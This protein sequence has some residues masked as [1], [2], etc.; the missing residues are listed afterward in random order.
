MGELLSSAA[1]EL[2]RQT[3]VSKDVAVKKLVCVIA[4]AMVGIASTFA[5]E[6]NAG[7]GSTR[8]DDSAMFAGPTQDVTYQVIWLI[9]SD[10]ANREAYSGPASG[11]L[12]EAGYGRL[13]RAGSATAAVTIGQPSTVTGKSRYGQMSVLTSLLNTTEQDKLQ[14]KVQLRI[15]NQTPL[16]IES[17]MRVPMDRWF[18]IGSADSR[19]GLPKHD[20][21][22]KRGLAIMKITDGVLLLDSEK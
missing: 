7:P 13:V 15:Q 20:A 16:S 18:L 21:D 10:D 22:G 4:C 8:F 1:V 14:I 6:P 9:E 5:Q 19:V 3:T 12:T 2:E 17:T 11:G